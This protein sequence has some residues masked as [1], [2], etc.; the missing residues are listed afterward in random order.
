MGRDL[1][2]VCGQGPGLG[3]HAGSQA[4]SQAGPGVPKGRWPQGEE[5]GGG[6]AASWEDPRQTGGTAERPH[7]QAVLPALC[8]QQASGWAPG[9]Q[10]RTPHPHPGSGRRASRRGSRWA[11]GPS[12]SWPC[13]AGDSPLPLPLRCSRC[14]APGVQAHWALPFPALRGGR[15]PGFS[16][17]PSCRVG[18]TLLP[19]GAGGLGAGGGQC[20]DQAA[21]QASPSGS[22]RPFSA[23]YKTRAIHGCR[24]R[25]P[26]ALGLSPGAVVETASRPRAPGRGRVVAMAQRLGWG[27]FGVEL[28]QCN[29][30]LTKGA[31]KSGI[32]ESFINGRRHKRGKAP[33]LAAR[34]AHHTPL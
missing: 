23:K 15:T 22:T 26:P 10:G 20:R 14:G 5:K 12:A 2:K 17:R 31:S 27:T 24:E 32:R 30:H 8:S 29:P 7:P 1:A 13:L 33:D 16:G 9:A 25:G 28:W 6:G 19:Q 34:T 18:C 21:P 11:P 3:A 4:A